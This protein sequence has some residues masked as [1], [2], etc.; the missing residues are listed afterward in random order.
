MKKI[1]LPKK[2]AFVN[3]FVSLLFTFFLVS[4]NTT[5][6]P[7]PKPEKPKVIAVKEITESCTE[8]FLT[9]SAKDTILPANVKIKRDCK[10]VMSF[11]QTIKD[12]TIVDAGLTAGKTYTY[13]PT[14][15]VSGKEEAG[16]QIQV[17]TLD[18][19]SSNFTW[20]TYTFG[21]HS[22]S[23]LNDVAIINDNDIWAMGEIYMND[24]TGNPDPHAYN[25]V[26][27]DG[28]KWGLKRIK[29]YTICG[30]KDKTPYPASSIFIFNKNEIWIAMDGDQI[31]IIKNNVQ[32][33]TICLSFSF[34]IKK[35]WGRSSKDVYAVGDNGN[36]AHY[37]GTN[38]EKIESGTNYL[39]QDIYGDVNPITGKTE[40][41][42][43]ACA[44]DNYDSEII[45][46]NENLTTEK[47][48]KVGLKKAVG[49][50][51]KP[52][53]RYYVTGDGLF[54]KKYKETN[55]WND[56][57]EGRSIT[58]NF[59]GAI[60]GNGLN[61]II[62]VGAFGEVIHYN[63][64]TWRSLKNEETTIYGWYGAVKIKGNQMVAVG[65]DGNKAVI[66]MGHR[67]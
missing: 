38:W 22:S 64:M 53:I 11:Y 56:L 13:Q 16:K 45:K 54:E 26:H 67:Q 66:L 44:R 61:D 15:N 21:E 51:F 23:T 19:T 47:L 63:G 7:P 55:S 37:D 31:A 30:Q 36:I 39:I 49:I 2:Y 48:D 20:K 34:S 65:F 28:E 40:I 5:E 14:V 24:S 57:N 41:L 62:V 9:V 17:S 10:E 50:W 59:M 3:L 25:A 18:T 32:V 35:L 46:I 1:K 33:A 60:W 12:T 29:F 6:P 27:W 43:T 52:G 4:C 8:I 58:S 42:C